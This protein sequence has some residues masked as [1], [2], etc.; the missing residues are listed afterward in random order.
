MRNKIGT[1]AISI[2]QHLYED[3]KVK[4]GATRSS[5]TVGKN[6]EVDQRDEEGKR[7]KTVPLY[8]VYNRVTAQKNRSCHRPEECGLALRDKER[9]G[10]EVGKPS[11]QVLCL[12]VSSGFRAEVRM[13]QI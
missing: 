10:G 3:L 1:G 6:S 12:I 7:K 2:F 4:M 11:C 5:L 13:L 8:C 9:E